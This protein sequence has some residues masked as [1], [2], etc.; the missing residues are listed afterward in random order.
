MKLA[1][2]V[3]SLP[4][5]WVESENCRAQKRLN[6][7]EKRNALNPY[8]IGLMRLGEM[9]VSPQNFSES[10]ISNIGYCSIW[11]KRCIVGRVHNQWQAVCDTQK[12]CDG[13]KAH[14]VVKG[15]KVIC[16]HPQKSGTIEQVL[17][18]YESADRSKPLSLMKADEIF[19]AGKGTRFRKKSNISA[20]RV[21]AKSRKTGE[22]VWGGMAK[23]E[24]CDQYQPS[25]IVEQRN[26]F[27]RGERVHMKALIRKANA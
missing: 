21:V 17:D 23:R 1:M 15:K 4:A 26:K 2:M 18:A 6:V 12:A 16:L 24:I 11:R 10:Q 25:V 14:Y 5:S 3:A 27:R 19:N 13:F 8:E 9:S 22:R 20:N 7:N